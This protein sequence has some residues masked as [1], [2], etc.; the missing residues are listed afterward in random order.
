MGR[1][2]TSCVLASSGWRIALFRVRSVAGLADLKEPI[3]GSSEK[4]RAR[5]QSAAARRDRVVKKRTEKSAATRGA[6]S[7]AAGEAAATGKVAQ[8]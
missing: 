5:E 3:M 2:A 8:N 6:T 7:G 4:K 1:Q